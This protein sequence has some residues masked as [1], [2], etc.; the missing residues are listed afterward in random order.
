LEIRDGQMQTT[1]PRWQGFNQIN[2]ILTGTLNNMDDL[3][4]NYPNIE[5]IK[6]DSPESYISD[7]ADFRDKFN[8]FTIVNPNPINETRNNLSI[9]E[10]NYISVNN[11][12]S[13]HR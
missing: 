2:S 8:N 3:Y 10:P 9:L 4:K 11:S 12:N 1:I 7:L 13:G 5:D 6:L